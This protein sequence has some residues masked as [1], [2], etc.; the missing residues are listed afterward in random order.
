MFSFC[1]INVNAECAECHGAM[2][3]EASC[4][5]H[6]PMTMEATGKSKIQLE[7]MCFDFLEILLYRISVY[8]LSILDV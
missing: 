7:P 8:L 1:T 5:H 3:S 2:A 4:S 6:V